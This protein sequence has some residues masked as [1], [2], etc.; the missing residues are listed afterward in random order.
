MSLGK[1]TSKN[2]LHCE[3]YHNIHAAFKLYVPKK[4][5]T[6]L[7]IYGALSTTELVIDSQFVFYIND[8]N[9]Y[10]K[11]YCDYTLDMDIQILNE[12]QLIFDPIKIKKL[13][14]FVENYERFNLDIPIK[15]DNE[16]ITE[17]DT[18]KGIIDKN[19]NIK[20]NSEM[21][22]QIIY[23]IYPSTIYDKITLNSNSLS[24]VES[25]GG[26]KET[27]IPIDA[28]FKG[29]WNQLKTEWKNCKTEEKAKLY[30]HEKIGIPID[31]ST[32]LYEIFE[33]DPNENDDDYPI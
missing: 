8:S 1:W 10:F 28:K 21:T 27:I 19:K 14:K 23:K 33:F 29:G 15:Y 32:V 5:S 25:F 17:W 24:V 26:P 16:E 9:D 4:N 2:Q 7:N 12:L 3:D 13:M 30:L 20:T 18:L 6:G 22:I 11:I 31:Y